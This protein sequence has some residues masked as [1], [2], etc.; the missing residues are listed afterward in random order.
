VSHPRRSVLYVPA[1][2]ARALEKARTLACDVVIFDL[3]D[4]VAPEMKPA[5]REA[6]FA[7]IREGGFAHRE[8]VVRV[9]ALDTEWGS[10]DLTAFRDSSVHA[11]LV[12]KICNSQDV[13]K[14]TKALSPAPSSLQLW[15]MIETPLSI[16]KLEE[17]AAT[18]PG[19]RLTCFVVGANDLATALRMPLDHRREPIAPM[20]AL[21]V[22][23]A[24]AHGLTVLDGVYNAFYD[25]AGFEAQC[26]QALEYGFD[27]KTLI[28]PRQI[29]VCNAVFS[30]SAPSLAW[31]QRVKAIFEKPENRGRG[32]LSLDGVMVER[33]HLAEAERLL[34]L[35]AAIRA[36]A[37]AVP[38]F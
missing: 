23:A 38:Q 10:R 24:R 27:G 35:D 29:E 20:L 2:N 21:T 33:L 25:L 7:A 3:E 9:N 22:A 36:L 17:I 19:S 30:P 12:P 11:I 4:A 5:A 6:A 15:A 37:L 14:Y 26:R 32:A 8:L 13:L 34:A 16:F 1:S 18:A 31:A 28:H